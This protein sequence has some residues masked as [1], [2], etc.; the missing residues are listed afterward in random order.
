MK[1]ILIVTS[2]YCIGSNIDGIGLRLWELA[3]VLAKHFNVIVL[4]NKISDFS[5]SGITFKT[6]DENWKTEVS[7]ADTVLF[8]DMPDTRIML[9]AYEK[10]KQIICENSIPIEHLD[11][12]NI[13]SSDNP[14]KS[15]QEILTR[16]KLQVLISDYFIVRSKVERVSMITALQMMGRLNYYNY[17]KE[18]QLSDLITYIPIGFNK[19]SDEYLK[20]VKPIQDKIDYVWSGGI[21]NFYSTSPIVKAIKKLSKENI[22]IKMLFMYKPPQNQYIEEYENL[23][24]NIEKLNLKDSITFLDGIFHYER[25]SY[26]IKS[27][28]IVCLG[29]DTIENYTCN[30]LRLR[31]VFLY[32]KPIIVDSYGAS[33]NLV[34]QYNIGMTVSNIGELV[35]A[36]KKLKYDKDYYQMCVENIKKVRDKFII[37]NNAFCLIKYIQCSKRSQDMIYNQSTINKF[38]ADN[39]IVLESPN[40]PF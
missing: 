32:N 28:A 22:D 10:G 3:Q 16:F 13:S 21:W 23:Q 11:Y 29:R 38:I 33:A 26:L 18:K 9:Y 6:F 24:I 4:S 14:N 34:S 12:T 37:D 7:L 19:E 15:Y 5:Y 17:S 25:D 36:L 27:K 31:D 30:R 8:C 40:Y 2:N 35:H 20:K 39:P 1:K